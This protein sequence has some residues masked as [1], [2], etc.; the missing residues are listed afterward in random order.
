MTHQGGHSGP[1]FGPRTRMSTRPKVASGLSFRKSEGRF[2]SKHLVNIDKECTKNRANMQYMKLCKTNYSAKG[3]QGDVTLVARE[4]A[5]DCKSNRSLLSS[6]A[7]QSSTLRVDY[8]FHP[9][10]QGVK[11]SKHPE[12]RNVLPS[13]KL[14]KLTPLQSKDDSNTTRRCPAQLM[15]RVRSVKKANNVGTSNPTNG[16]SDSMSKGQQSN[17]CQ[18]DINVGKDS[19]KNSKPFTDKVSKGLNIS[20]ASEPLIMTDKNSNNEEGRPDNVMANKNKEV[21]GRTNE[22]HVMCDHYRKKKD[23]PNTNDAPITGSLL[24]GKQHVKDLKSNSRKD[25]SPL[26]GG[27]LSRHLGDKASYMEDKGCSILPSKHACQGEFGERSSKLPRSQWALG[28]AN[29]G[30]SKRRREPMPKEKPETHDDNKSE[31]PKRRRFIDTSEDEEVDGFDQS[32][33]GVEDGTAELIPQVAVAKDSVHQECCCCSKPIDE[34]TWSGNFMIDGKE[35]IELAAHLSTKAGKKVWELSGSLLPLVELAKV[36]M[37]EAW[38]KNWESS[39]P[40]G[41][42]IGLF[43]FPDKMRHDKD[44][45]QL[46]KEITENGLVLRAVM[47]E[48]EML[49]FSSSLL[50]ERHKTF[51]RKHY[52]WGVFKPRE[53]RF[54]VIAERLNGAGHCALEE[55][56]EEQHVSNE[57]DEVQCEEPDQEMTLK[58]P[59]PLENQWLSARSTQ[60]VHGCSVQGQTNMGLELEAPEEGRLGN[61]S[62][63]AVHTTKAAAVATNA[64]TVPAESTDAACVPTEAALMAND[65]ATLPANHGRI[66]SSMGNPAG[67][68]FVIITRQTPNLEHRVRQF[69]KDMEEDGVSV[70]VIQ[71]EAMG[72]GP[73]P[74]NTATITP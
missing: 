8:G 60:Q 12:V 32:P 15:P 38:P 26:F 52:L 23:T 25:S 48:A 71:G 55:D 65:A 72:A 21:K 4:V 30:K 11:C 7:R 28:N 58:C 27:D 14:E 29:D 36:S 1:Y 50:P 24:N 13:E 70:V 22:L 74:G 19:S 45:D 9:S 54:A 49:I 37:A 61:A 53:D 41:D 44:L 66:D 16:A 57:Q 3:E 62:P 6:H 67:S 31:R 18:E 73:C 33:V 2:R 46:V 43:F 68:V 64:T 10:S 34:P 40:T 17:L 69:V 63:H 47:G 39:K 20:M 56:K 59:K 51:R 5:D 35:Y 42:S